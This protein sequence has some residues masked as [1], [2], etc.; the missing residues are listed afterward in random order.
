MQAPASA[1]KVAE[2]LTSATQ[3]VPNLALFAPVLA[4]ALGVSFW[5]PTYVI[6]CV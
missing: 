6:L 3:G 2:W 1:D 5:F 4:D